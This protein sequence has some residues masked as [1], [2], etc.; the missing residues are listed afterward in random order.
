MKIY[1]KLNVKCVKYYDFNIFCMTMYKFVYVYISVHVYFY[2]NI[3][4]HIYPMY[5]CIPMTMSD[6]YVYKNINKWM[7]EFLVIFIFYLYFSL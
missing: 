4:I 5:S 3:Y 1:F 2:I 7:V 6:R